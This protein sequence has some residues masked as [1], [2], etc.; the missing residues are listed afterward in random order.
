M[1]DQE[2]TSAPHCTRAAGMRARWLRREAAVL[3]GDPGAAA[4]VSPR[5]G[6]SSSSPYIAPWPMVAAAGSWPSR[7]RA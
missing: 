3:V 5:P 1:D 6:Y 2:P 4:N 7:C